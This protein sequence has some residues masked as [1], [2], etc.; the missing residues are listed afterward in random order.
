MGTRFS[1]PPDR[2]WGPPGLL[3][4][5][6]RFFPGCR[7]GR[8]VGLTPHPHLVP[9]VLEKSRAIPV[10]SLRACVSHKRLKIYLKAYKWNKHVLAI[11]QQNC[12]L[13]CSSQSRK[14]L[15][16]VCGFIRFVGE[17]PCVVEK[18]WTKIETAI[19]NYGGCVMPNWMG[20]IWYFK[21]C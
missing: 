2:P 5:G 10:L 3:Y 7:G 6:H 8:D 4:N 16:S 17:M 11:P 1:A 19:Q 12:P 21:R 14:E 18:S 20:S 9:N 13:T 15:I